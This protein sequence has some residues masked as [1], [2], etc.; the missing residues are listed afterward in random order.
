M[1]LIPDRGNKGNFFFVTPRP[2]RL[3]DPPTQP[4][5]QWVP[6]YLI[7]GLKR[8]RREADHTPPS[9]AGVKDALNY[10]SIPPHIFMSWCLIKH[11]V[12]LPG[13]VLSYTQ[14]LLYLTFKYPPVN[15][16]L[17]STNSCKKLPLYSWIWIT[18]HRL[19][20][21]YIYVPSCYKTLTFCFYFLNCYI[22]RKSYITAD[23]LLW[24]TFICH[25]IHTTLILYSDFSSN[26][27]V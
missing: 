11:M 16:T 12:R 15:W 8:P 2:D 17:F 19:S 6:E 18:I 10:T 27:W 21:R 13:A 3:R 9:S 1:G 26:N 20:V 23:K 22:A 24:G 25:H 4:S 7:T 14:R 5:T